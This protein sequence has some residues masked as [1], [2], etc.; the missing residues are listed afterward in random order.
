[1]SVTCPS[2]G[3]IEVAAL[4]ET[5]SLQLRVVSGEDMVDGGGSRMGGCD[6]E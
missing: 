1:M 2:V 5:M 6:A 3:V 4:A